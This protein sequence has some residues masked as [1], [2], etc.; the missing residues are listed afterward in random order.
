M[1]LKWVRVVITFAPK[2]FNQKKNNDM[3]KAFLLLGLALASALPGFCEENPFEKDF[4]IWEWDFSNGKGDVYTS[5]FSM[6]DGMTENPTPK[7]DAW[8]WDE[9]TGCMVSDNQGYNIDMWEL[10][11]R[12]IPL[13]DLDY[14]DIRISFEYAATRNH[15]FSTYIGISSTNGKDLSEVKFPYQFS[16]ADDEIVFVNSGDIQ[17]DELNGGTVSISFS[18]G[19]TMRNPNPKLY[20]KKITIKGKHKY[21]NLPYKDITTFRELKECED[22]TVI[23]Y[24]NPNL[25]LMMNDPNFS[26]LR[27]E[28]GSVSVNDY[29]CQYEGTKMPNT[30]RAVYH[31]LSNGVPEISNIS[32][33]WDGD[34]AEMGY[35]KPK[36]ISEGEYWDN[37]CEFVVMPITQKI[38]LLDNA[39]E[40]LGGRTS[41][42]PHNPN[43]KITGYIYPT[44]DGKVRF[45]YGYNCSVEVELSETEGFVVSED[46]KNFVRYKINRSFSKDSW[47]TLTL[48]SSFYDGWNDYTVAEFV[49]GNDGILTFQTVNTME[50]GKPYL[51]KFKKDVSKLEGTLSTSDAQS[52][53]GGD[54]N[55]V[56]TLSA[57]QPKDGSYY[58]TSGNTIKPLSSGG[59]I[60]AFRAFFEPSTPNAAKARA[61][62]ID[63]E[64]TDI[65][66]IIINDQRL[67][68]SAIYNLSGQRLNNS[69][70]G[71]L[72]I[73]NGKKVIK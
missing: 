15:S 49:S 67:G 9:T 62:S 3:K 46:E 8:Y 44:E 66:D 52:V 22:G 65:K 50:A 19:N 11:V 57:T 69:E 70:R 31:K 33:Q 26:F 43:T 35:T 40:L 29:L 6:E 2:N 38:L 45:A 32:Y 17:I 39:G 21:G 63:G 61:I 34:N 60:N 24:N 56:G 5:Q 73:I 30:L 10:Y 48:P 7:P 68:E 59:T 37:L 36:E 53:Y 14:S 42:T 20:I 51:V 1:I 41:F 55:F 25:T 12:N 64:T 23:R 16:T 4:T 58:L 54:Y 27:D 13:N 72:Y 47:Y 18:E 71:G 28:T